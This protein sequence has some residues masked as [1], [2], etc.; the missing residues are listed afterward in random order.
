MLEFDN[1]KTQFL[2]TLP[3]NI[4]DNLPQI[5]IAVIDEAIEAVIDGRDEISDN[6][7]A[8]TVEEAL[9]MINYSVL[10]RLQTFELLK[11]AIKANYPKGTV[12]NYR[13]IQIE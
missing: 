2:R 10:H 7:K 11:G 3:G 13:G 5:Y 1:L 6:N 12:F 4:S 8:N 9:N